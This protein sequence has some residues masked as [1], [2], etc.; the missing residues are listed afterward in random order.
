MTVVVELDGV[1]RELPVVV[2]ENDA[3]RRLT[4]VAG[5]QPIDWR[6]R[7]RDGSLTHLP[8]FR[9]LDADWTR[10]EELPGVSVRF[11]FTYLDNPLGLI[12]CQFDVVDG[13]PASVRFGPPESIEPSSEVWFRVP[14]ERTMRQFLGEIGPLELMAPPSERGGDLDAAMVVAGLLGP[15]WRAA[16][17][18]EP[19]DYRDLIAGYRALGGRP[20]SAWVNGLQGW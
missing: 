1:E 4:L 8:P 3:T 18:M 10:M 14:I 6:M 15:E 9:V 12:S 17:A 13:R 16:Q 11:A 20:L 2:D 19:E 7:V 5:E